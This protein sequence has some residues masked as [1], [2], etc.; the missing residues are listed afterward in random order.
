MEARRVDAGDVHTLRATAA[1]AELWAGSERVLTIEATEG[2]MAVR[3]TN[4]AMGAAAIELLGDQ[5]IEIVF[6][7]GP[8]DAASPH[9]SV[10][11]ASGSGRRL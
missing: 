2:G 7:R 10:T 8:E 5:A 6:T 9:A 11:G 3:A 4:T 1:S